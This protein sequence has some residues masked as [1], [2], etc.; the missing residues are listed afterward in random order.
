MDL[1]STFMR[2]LW[3]SIPGGELSDTADPIRE[4]DRDV[5][6]RRRDQ[7]GPAIRVRGSCLTWVEWVVEVD[8]VI[9]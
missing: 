3:Y 5:P 4:L 9:W 7:E 1:R 6:D 2:L 8:Q